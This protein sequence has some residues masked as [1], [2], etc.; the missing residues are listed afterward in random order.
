MQPSE[1]VGDGTRAVDIL[2]TWPGGKPV[3]IEVEG[4]HHFLRSPG[5]GLNVVDTPTRLRNHVLERWG[6]AVVQVNRQN[7]GV[8][9]PHVESDKFRTWL[10]GKLRD[11]GVP[12]PR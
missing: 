11:A 5:G 1:A 9:Y 3:A 12:V 2:L 6:F 10:E 4:P 7:A 8:D